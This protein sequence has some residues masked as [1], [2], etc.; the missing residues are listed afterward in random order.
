MYGRVN[1]VPKVVSTYSLATILAMQLLIVIINQNNYYLFIKI[2][3]F[4]V[5]SRSMKVFGIY[6]NILLMKYTLF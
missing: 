1:I 6:L 3:T 4:I 5:L 2:Q